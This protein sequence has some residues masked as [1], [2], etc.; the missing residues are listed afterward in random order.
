MPSSNTIPL[1]LLAD[2]RIG[3]AAVRVAVDVDP[4]SF[5]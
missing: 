2:Q 1:D 4:V 3:H 5:F